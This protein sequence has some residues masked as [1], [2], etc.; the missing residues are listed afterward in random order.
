[1]TGKIIASSAKFWGSRISSSTRGMKDKSMWKSVS[2]IN[3]L[4]LL[5]IRMFHPP[6]LRSIRFCR[7]F[8]WFRIKTTFLR[9][10]MTVSKTSV[11]ISGKIL[12]NCWI[13]MIITITI[14]IIITIIIT[15]ITII[16]TIIILIWISIVIPNTNK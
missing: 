15:I 13:P 1:M 16:I 6:I 4:L 12:K 7:M 14:I 2:M 8:L 11:S 10:K 9:M 5:L 3:R